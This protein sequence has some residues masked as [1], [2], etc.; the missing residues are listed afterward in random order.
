MSTVNCLDGL[1]GDP[2][3]H[4]HALYRTDRDET[5][6]GYYQLIL[7]TLT[8]KEVNRPGVPY[9]TIFK[10]S[11]TGGFVIVQPKKVQ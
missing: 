2:N 8:S 6:H 1:N 9:L 3:W 11:K 10:G 4:L 5:I 7:K